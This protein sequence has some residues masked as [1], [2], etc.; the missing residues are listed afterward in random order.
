MSSEPSAARVIW[1]MQRS[2]SV[3][4]PP[5]KW[6][7]KTSPVVVPRQVNMPTAS[8]VVPSKCSVHGVAM[9]RTEQLLLWNCV[10]VQA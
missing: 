4:W 5:K 7:W 10:G 6:H 2:S 1:K 9:P 3:F 8:A